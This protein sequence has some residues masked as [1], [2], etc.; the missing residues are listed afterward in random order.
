MRPGCCNVQ[1]ELVW[2]AAP[3]GAT[4]FHLCIYGE[5]LMGVGGGG[6]VWLYSACQPERVAMRR[7][8][9]STGTAPCRCIQSSCGAQ[10]A[11]DKRSVTEHC[12]PRATT[13]RA[14]H[15]ARMR[16][17]GGVG[18]FGGDGPVCVAVLSPTSRGVLPQS[19]AAVAPNVACAAHARP[20]RPGTQSNYSSALMSLSFAR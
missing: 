16:S 20:V 5:R 9:N 14:M 6:V 2:R 17:H 18:G 19:N 11:P 15:A 12:S 3:S 4:S 10:R 1:W 13:R 8:Y 7:T